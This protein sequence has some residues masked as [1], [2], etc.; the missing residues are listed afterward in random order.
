MCCI[1]NHAWSQ[2][3]DFPYIYCGLA[4][5]MNLLLFVCQRVCRFPI[6]RYR[7]CCWIHFRLS[8]TPNLGVLPQR[9]LTVFNI[10]LTTR[11]FDNLSYDICNKW[12]WFGHNAGWCSFKWRVNCAIRHFFLISLKLW[13][14]LGSNC[15][16][17]K[18]ENL[19]SIKSQISAIPKTCLRHP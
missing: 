3:L 9:Q 13:D 2:C 8:Q 18:G 17:K 14:V 5:L 11:A 7:N 16:G 15:R 10:V 6:R 1:A 4:K 12:F 19:N